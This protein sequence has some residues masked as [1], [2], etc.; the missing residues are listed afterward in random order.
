VVTVTAVDEAGNAT[1]REKQVTM[2][3]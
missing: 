3:R 1:R 2:L